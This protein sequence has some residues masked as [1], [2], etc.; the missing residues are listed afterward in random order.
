MMLVNLKSY[1]GVGKKWN[2]ER[3]LEIEGSGGV[4][5]NRLFW[6]GFNERWHLH[7]GS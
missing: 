3:R 1:G 6:E 5:L 7:K 4:A 2:N